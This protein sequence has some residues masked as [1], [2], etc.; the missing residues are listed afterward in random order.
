MNSW[1]TVS[2]N[3]CWGSLTLGLLCYCFSHVTVFCIL[4]CCLC[5]G[6]VCLSVYCKHCLLLSEMDIQL[7]KVLGTKSITADPGQLLFFLLPWNKSIFIPP[8]FLMVQYQKFNVYPFKIYENKSEKQRARV[9]KRCYDCRDFQYS[10]WPKEKYNIWNICLPASLW[11][12]QS[13]TLNLKLYGKGKT[14]HI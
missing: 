5:W 11:I 8:L 4:S 9:E 13:R 10:F 6:G 1:I 3:R 7:Q 12:C 14:K 2:V